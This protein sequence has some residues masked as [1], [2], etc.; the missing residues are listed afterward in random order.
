MTELFIRPVSYS[1]YFYFFKLGIKQEG[2]QIRACHDRYSF[3]VLFYETGTAGVKMCL[4]RLGYVLWIILILLGF[5]LFGNVKGH[6]FH[7]WNMAQIF[8]RFVFGFYGTAYRRN[9]SILI[10]FFVIILPKFVLSKESDH[11]WNYVE[12]WLDIIENWPRS[13]SFLSSIGTWNVWGYK[14]NHPHHL[15]TKNRQDVPN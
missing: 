4:T 9:I 10:Y 5:L 12:Y 8:N 11:T 15:L 3:C 13:S 14:L 6:H 2:L 7:Y 1:F